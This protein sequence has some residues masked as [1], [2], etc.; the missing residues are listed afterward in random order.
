MNSSQQNHTPPRLN[1]FGG[2]LLVFALV[3]AV[4]S[5]PPPRTGVRPLFGLGNMFLPLF[6]SAGAVLLAIVG[7]ILV[8]RELVRGQTGRVQR[9]ALSALIPVGAVTIVGGYLT[10]VAGFDVS[11]PFIIGVYTMA[12][13]GGLATELVN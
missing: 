2:A 8:A 4:I 6:P 5:Y 1:R 11:V 7:G 3:T 9:L 10:V 13:M 12:A